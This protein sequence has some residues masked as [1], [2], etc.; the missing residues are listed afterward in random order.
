MDMYAYNKLHGG[1]VD[2][3]IAALK[4]HEGTGAPGKPLTGHASAAKAA[5]TMDKGN[6]R[7]ILEASIGLRAADGQFVPYLD[8]EVNGADDFIADY[9]EAADSHPI[10]TYKIYLWRP[11]KGRTPGAWVLVQDTA[12][13]GYGSEAAVI[14]AIAPRQNA[15]GEH[16]F[17]L[18]QLSPSKHCVS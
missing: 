13:P 4:E 14:V 12:E 10:G 9:A 17:P 3:F 16:C 18:A 2:A 1:Q 7:K 15:A 8:R 5:A 11:P 6:V